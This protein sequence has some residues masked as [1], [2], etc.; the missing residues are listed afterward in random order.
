MDEYQNRL[1]DTGIALQETWGSTPAFEAVG[2]VLDRV[3]MYIYI[4]VYI[5]IYICIYI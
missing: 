1:L 3:C 2:A 5:S 4:Y